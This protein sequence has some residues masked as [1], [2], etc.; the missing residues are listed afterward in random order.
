MLGALDAA[1]SITR[2][3]Y[4]CNIGMAGQYGFKGGGTPAGQPTLARYA[5]DYLW[6]DNVIVG[7]PGSGYPPTTRFAPSLDAVGFVAPDS[8]DYTL[9]GNSPYKRRCFDGRDPG[10]DMARVEQATSGVVTP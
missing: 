6:S 2:L 7:R 3:T 8:G 1:P 4:R 5:P 9:R 10:A